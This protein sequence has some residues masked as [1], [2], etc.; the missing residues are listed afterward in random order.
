MTFATRRFTSLA[1]DLALVLAMGAVIPVAV[2]A[3]IAF[4]V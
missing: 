4:I 3:A 1:R 2:V